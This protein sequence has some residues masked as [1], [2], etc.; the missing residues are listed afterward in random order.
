MPGKRRSP[1]GHATLR[2]SIIGA[3]CCTMAACG[4]VMDSRF[5]TLQAA[6]E[7]DMVRKGW[8]PEWVPPDATDLREVHDLDSNVSELA[9][10]KPVATQIRL[11]AHC[12]KTRYSSSAR[13]SIQR[14][15][16][17]PEPLLQMSYT[18]FTC[19]PDYGRATFAAVSDS[20]DHVLFWRTY[21]D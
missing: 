20:G 18:I 16:W 11:P 10:R 1:Q 19:G 13:A 3:L 14:S 5:D 17:P 6:R 15:W 2:A 7:Q 12:R 4:L 9:F 8:V 21:S